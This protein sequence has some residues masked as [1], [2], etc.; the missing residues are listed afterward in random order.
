M[1]WHRPHGDV[2]TDRLVYWFLYKKKMDLPFE[3]FVDM[4]D[5]LQKPVRVC[6]VNIEKEMQQMKA[7]LSKAIWKKKNLGYT[8][9]QVTEIK[10]L[11]GIPSDAQ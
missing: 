5:E 11:A 3:Q 2:I 6:K 1:A 8:D 7:L 10:V 4:V 9:A